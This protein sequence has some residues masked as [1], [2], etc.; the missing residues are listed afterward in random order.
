MDKDTDRVEKVEKEKKSIFK[1]IEEQ[2][3]KLKKLQAK[4]EK[5]INLKY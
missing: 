5:K 4:K 2:Q 1:Q 3:V